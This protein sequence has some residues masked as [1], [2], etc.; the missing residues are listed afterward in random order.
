[1]GIFEWPVI[2]AAELRRYRGA[3]VADVMRQ[4]NVDHLLLTGFDTI[5]YALDLRV[6]LISEG[7]D[8]FAA[9]SDID[10]EAVLF[11]PWIG[12]DSDVRDVYMPRVRK[13]VATPSWTSCLNQLEIWTHLLAREIVASGARRVGVDSLPFELFES[14]RQAVPQVELVPIYRALGRARQVKHPIEMRLI[15]AAG[16]ANSIAS[17][18]AVARAHEGAT[19]FEVLSEAMATLQRL[20][21]EY[22]THSLCITRGSQLAGS[23]FPKGRRLWEGDPFFFDIGCYG[24]GG[25]ASDMARTGFVGEPG[26]AVRQAYAA[27]M[28]ALGD[29]LEILRPG[30]HVSEVFERINKSLRQ[31]GFGETPYSVGH[32]IGVRACEE[33][34][35]YRKDMMAHDAIIEEGM[36][37]AVEPETT[38][39]VDGTQVV[40]KIEDSDA[41]ERT[42]PRRF[43]PGGY[44]AGVS[45]A[46]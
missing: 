5:R 4:A 1:M 15:E 43:T 30:T 41:I 40:L 3:R 10:G 13:S 34:I 28:T 33:P 46:W 38:V 18:A 12:E 8:W 9:L 31:Q 17:A 25:Y 45:A 29:G 37:L 35:I 27:L 11:I 20:G 7:H 23:W 21:V 16:Q 39:E 32:G 24:V 19:D 26:K 2:D 36:A 42:G 6:M 14:L 22:M 44:G